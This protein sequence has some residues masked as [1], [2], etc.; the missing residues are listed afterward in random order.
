MH[1]TVAVLVTIGLPR[2]FPHCSH[3]L[4]GHIP[5]GSLTHRPSREWLLV[6]V[7]PCF[8]GAGGN[9]VANISAADDS[10][11]IRVE[12]VY[13][14]RAD[15]R[16]LDALYKQTQQTIEGAAH[17]HGW[18]KWV[19]LERKDYPQAEDFKDRLTCPQSS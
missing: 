8:L 7:G 16:E 3:R 10:E 18:L 17:R 11:T 12:L 19:K 14:V 13:N 15:A 6:E 1:D 5:T 9:S 2:P 4:R